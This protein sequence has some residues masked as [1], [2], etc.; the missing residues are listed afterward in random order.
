MKIKLEF[1]TRE[2]AGD[3][4]LVPV[5]KTALELNGMLTLN[6]LGAFLWA[7]LPEAEDQEALVQAVLAEYAVEPEQARA[8]VEQFLQKLASLGIL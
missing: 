6:E 4:L 2:V 5:G 1:V 8:D 7:R 3:T